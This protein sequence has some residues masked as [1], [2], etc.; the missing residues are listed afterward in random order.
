MPR[1]VGSYTYAP[2]GD[3]PPAPSPTTLS[4]VADSDTVRAI[5][6]IALIFHG[7]RRTDS[8]FWALVYG[9]AGRAVPTIAVPIALAQGFGTK[10]VCP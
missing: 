3:A 6:A 5:S 10:K 7:Y 2:L 8:V 9:M 4:D 1:L